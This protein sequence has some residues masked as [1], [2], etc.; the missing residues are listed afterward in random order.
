MRLARVGAFAAWRFV[1]EASTAPQRRLLHGPRL[2]SM[3]PWG[4][5]KKCQRTCGGGWAPG[6]DNEM[7]YAGAP[8]NSNDGYCSWR[9]KIAPGEAQWTTQGDGW[10]ASNGAACSGYVDQNWNPGDGWGTR[11]WRSDGKGGEGA[12]KGRWSNKLTYRM[13][14]KDREMRAAVYL[15]LRADGK[16][17]ARSKLMPDWRWAQQQVSQSQA[18]PLW[19][20]PVSPPPPPP[21]EDLPPPAKPPPGPPP[22]GL[23]G[24]THV[25]S[26]GLGETCDGSQLYNRSEVLILHPVKRLEWNGPLVLICQ[27]CWEA[28]TGLTTNQLEFRK[29]ANRSWDSRDGRVHG[30]D[31]HF[32]A[33]GEGPGSGPRCLPG[34]GAAMAREGDQGPGGGGMTSNPYMALVTLP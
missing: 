31:Q 18:R 21:L 19:K 5:H 30:Q 4:K 12:T 17:E 16:E 20:T 27:Q 34:A 10:G 2:G 32:A 1:R 25:C 8:D 22:P 29:W 24:K 33:E 11:H 26:S 9:R 28:R 14:H 3:A 6:W 23:R 7:V 13:P 15:A